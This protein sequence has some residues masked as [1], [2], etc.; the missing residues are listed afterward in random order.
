MTDLCKHHLCSAQGNISML[1][2]GWK[3]LFL[4]RL[5]YWRL[6]HWLTCRV[7]EQLVQSSTLG[8]TLRL[9]TSSIHDFGPL[10]P[11]ALLAISRNKICFKWSSFTLRSF[12][13]SF[14]RVQKKKKKQNIYNYL[15]VITGITSILKTD[16]P[17]FL[18][19][20]SSTSDTHLHLC[21]ESLE[22]ISSC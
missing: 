1:H 7:V 14:R 15:T 11:E 8:K 9:V 19:R 13:I 16:V 22:V 21:W 18:R 5:T 6:W 20:L 4:L 2:C 17:A 10:S 12:A 3:S